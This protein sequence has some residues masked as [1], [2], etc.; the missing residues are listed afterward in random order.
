MNEKPARHT[1][2]ERR[3]EITA[4]AA[5]EFARRGLEGATTD[6]IAERAGV[7]Q[8]Y[9]VRLFGTK[10]ALFLAVANRA[11][12]RVADAFR[13]AAV[14]EGPD[15]RLENMGA[16]YVALLSDRDELALQLQLYAAAYDPEI[17]TCVATRF[18]QLHELCGEL[19][20]AE[21]KRL[22]EFIAQGMLCNVAAALD[23][24]QIAWDENWAR[25]RLSELGGGAAEAAGQAP[26]KAVAIVD[27]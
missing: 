27:P 2:D 14:G 9:V 1:A 10:K 17:R 24:P 13:A 25:E 23:M 19:S 21:P 4:A 26:A 15:E 18:A 3:I 16:A 7:S 5:I 11:F 6:R 12:E 20:G 8:P 22:R